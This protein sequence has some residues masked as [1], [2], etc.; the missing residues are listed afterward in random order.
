MEAIEKVF[1]EPKQIQLVQ[2]SMT[3]AKAI[4]RK[5]LISATMVISAGEVD[6]KLY[7]TMEV[8]K[9]IRESDGKIAAVEKAIHDRMLASCESVKDN[10]RSIA[11]LIADV[12]AWKALMMAPRQQEAKQG[13]ELDLNDE[14]KDASIQDATVVKSEASENLDAW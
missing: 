12:R 14:P 7:D 9:S 11:T 3:D 2:I 6:T 5:S 13:S 8:I 4:V 10:G 1:D